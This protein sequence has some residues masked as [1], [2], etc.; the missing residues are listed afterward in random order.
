[1]AIDVIS[2]PLGDIDPGDLRAVARHL[3]ARVRRESPEA[4]VPSTSAVLR[5]ALLDPSVL[6]GLPDESGVRSLRALAALLADVRG[7]IGNNAPPAEVLWRLWT[8]TRWPHR[9]RQRALRG[10]TSADHDLD[11][12][13]ALFDTAE[14]MTQRLGGFRGIGD[15][16]STLRS[17]LLPAEQVAELAADIDR[18]RILTAH[19]AKGL[20]WDVVVVAGVQEGV[21]P[22]TRQRGSVL[23]ADRLTAE[24]VG[25]PPEPGAMLAEEERLLYVAVTRA[26]RSLLIAAVQPS[27]DGAA[28]PSRLL[29]RIPVRPVH[30]P[31]RP[32]RRSSLAGM[33]AEL[34]TT[35]QDPAAGPAL[36][37]AAAARL[38]RLAAESVDG[39]PIAPAADPSAWWGRA[40]V[41]PG[42][43]PVRPA[44]EPLRLSASAVESV[45]TC[46]LRWF[47]DRQARVEV[48]RSA[49]LA[50]GS[51]IHAIAEHIGSGDV[52]PDFDSA[53]AL[54]EQVWPMLGFDATFTAE[55]ERTAAREAL[56][57]FLLYHVRD[58]RALLRAE[59]DFTVAFDTPHGPV[60]VRGS[61]DRLEQDAEG[62]LVPVDFKTGRQGLTASEVA[63]HL[64]LALYQWAVE[65]GAFADVSTQSGGAALVHLR[66]PAG[67]GDDGPKV[68]EQPPSAQAHAAVEDALSTA[69]RRIRAE[70]FHATPGRHCASCRYKAVCPTGP[71]EVLR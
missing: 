45:N 48:P 69:A 71:G 57:R 64:Q 33:I 11:A 34:R 8:G 32:T 30:I 12:V 4:P 26:R 50:F 9:L 44:D 51:I 41:S 66:L 31:G 25:D 17:Q 36:R 40:E 39:R 18:V 37:A 10:S 6:D 54:L 27:N 14:R 35:A 2:G 3:R 28:P 67:K 55:A 5:E 23:Q 56:R 63:E 15:F 1:M 70:E 19:R 16:V 65:R 53:D 59:A 22:D 46:G 21:W 52:A 47:L 13:I 29:E 42:R 60:D 24:G 58:A 68:Q 20:E 61:L 49:A 38:A 62:A 7:R 43:I